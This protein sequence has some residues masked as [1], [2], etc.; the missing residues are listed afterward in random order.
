VPDRDK[1][2]KRPRNRKRNNEPQEPGK[3]DRLDRQ[4]MAEQ[5]GYAMAFLRHDDELWGLFQKATQNNWSRV[6]FQTELLDTKWFKK[7]PATYRQ[8]MARKFSDPATFEQERR[9]MFQTL[10]STASQYSAI[11]G[12]KTL[13]QM[14]ETAILFGWTDEQ[15]AE[16]MAKYVRATRGH[17]GGSLASVEEQVRETAYRNGVPLNKKAMDNW[18]RQIVRGQATLEEYNAAV[19]AHA[20]RTFKAFGQEINGGMDLI[21]VASPYLETARQILELGPQ[22]IDLFDKRVRKAL[23][24]RDDK[25]RLEPLG[26][27]EFEQDLRSD[28]RWRHTSNARESVMGAAYEVQRMMGVRS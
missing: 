28:P 18:M 10:Q 14:S 5:Y 17:Y 26:L 7:H 19:R 24:H 27:V 12:N 13:K 6:K 4:R 3:R 20:A 1:R 11:I 21:D 22:D 15:V 23:T 9:Q 16:H 25:G 2:R 8:G